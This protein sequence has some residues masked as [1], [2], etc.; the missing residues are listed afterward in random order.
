[1]PEST[2]HRR[3]FDEY[4]DLGAARSIE[5]LHTLLQSKGGAPGVRTLYEWSRRYR[6]QDR[7][8]RLEQE[9]RRADDESRVTALR[10]MYDRHAREAL[11]LQQ[12]G[13][14]WLT[15]VG[16]ER[17]TVDGAIRAIVEGARMERLARGESTE[18]ME[19]SGELTIS[20]RLAAI[21]D[22]E[23]DRLLELTHGTLGGESATRPE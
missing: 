19:T 16:D 14:E 4:W 21:T 3:A 23:L 15:T 13:A 7:I 1:M 20:G 2:R 8:A 18:R 10:E 17:V 6:W 5:A 9:A 22:E 11:L 12:R